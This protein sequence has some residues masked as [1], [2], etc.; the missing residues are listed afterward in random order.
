MTSIT[1]AL[2]VLRRADLRTGTLL[3]FALDLTSLGMLSLAPGDVDGESA[4]YRIKYKRRL[5]HTAG[6]R[7][8]T[9][10]VSSCCHFWRCAEL[11]FRCTREPLG[12]RWI[13][14]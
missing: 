2:G 1:G 5:T 12:I 7:P 9:T 11:K 3:A 10:S 14:A 13:V 4:N 8:A 6:L